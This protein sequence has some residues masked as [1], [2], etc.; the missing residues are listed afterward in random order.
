MAGS[1]P[2]TVAGGDG[3]CWPV[4]TPSSVLPS[5]VTV[6]V[7]YRAAREKEQAVGGDPAAPARLHVVDGTYELF[8]AHFSKR[9]GRTAPDGRDVKAT[10]GLV[11]SLLALLADDAQA[12]THLG[13]AFDRPIESWR[14]ERFEG[15]KSSEGVDPALLAQLEGA[16]EAV[17]AL[18]IHVWRGIEVEADDLLASAAVQLADRVGQVRLLSPDKDLAQ[19]VRGERIVQVDRARDIVRDE[20]G[21]RSRFGITPT[22]VPDLL[23]LVGDDADGIPG[24]PGIGAKTAAVLLDRYTHLTEIPADPTEW[25]VTVRGAARIAATLTER[26]EDALVY[27]ELTRLATDLEL[28]ADLEDLA[29]RGVPRRRFLAWCD[30]L[31][32]DQLRDRPR[33]WA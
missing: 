18:G 30:A 25:D 33:R 17:A 20:A 22:S 6:A 21:V 15:Y 10:V 26:R 5:R 13:V 3:S 9:P 14:N 27:R 24:L 2:S 4:S 1:A 8:R 11:A 29:H 12:V 28:G 32:V 19:V 23:A 31:G 7:D 16:E